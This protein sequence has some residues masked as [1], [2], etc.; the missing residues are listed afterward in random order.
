MTELGESP[1]ALHLRLRAT[2]GAVAIR[3]ESDD[4]LYI[5]QLRAGP[6]KPTDHPKTQ[7]DMAG[8]YGVDC[9]AC[10]RPIFLGPYSQTISD[11]TLPLSEGPIRCPYC[12]DRTIY[13]QDRLVYY[14]RLT[15]QELFDRNGCGSASFV[16]GLGCLRDLRRF[17][18]WF[19]DMVKNPPIT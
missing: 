8:F 10:T 19:C 11:V 9:P 6:V 1:A 4:P 16:A 5:A 18:D 13:G 17:V 14:E 2:I 12:D 7:A 15:E 3:G